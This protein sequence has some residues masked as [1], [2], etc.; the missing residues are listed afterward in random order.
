MAA[1]LPSDIFAGYELVDAAG[2]VTADSIVIPLAALP[3]LSE[4]EAHETTGN[5]AQLLRAIDKAIHNALTA[6]PEVDRPTNVTFSLNTETTSTTTRTAE[7]ARRYFESAPAL[8][9]D[10]AEEA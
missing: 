10:L 4:A 2:T 1:I 8:A 5:G 7:Y 6:L 9:F 3:E